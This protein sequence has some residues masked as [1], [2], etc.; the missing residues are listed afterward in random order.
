MRRSRTFLR[1]VA[2]TGAPGTPRHEVSHCDGPEGNRTPNLLRAK[3]ALFSLSYGGPTDRTRCARV[4]APRCP[5]L[6]SNQHLSLL[7]GARPSSCQGSWPEGSNPLETTDSSSVVREPLRTELGADAPGRARGAMERVGIEPTCSGE[8]RCYGP[9][10]APAASAPGR[11]NLANND[12]R[13]TKTS[14]KE[15]GSASHA[16]RRAERQVGG[17]RARGRRRRGSRSERGG[18]L[19]QR[20]SDLA[21]GTKKAAP[22]SLGGLSL[23]GCANERGSLGVIHLGIEEMV[24]IIATRTAKAGALES[25]FAAALRLRTIQASSEAGTEHRV[26]QG[27]PEHDRVAALLCRRRRRPA[28]GGREG[29][30]ELQDESHGEC[31]CCRR[32]RS[33]CQTKKNAANKIE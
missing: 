23:R 30:L 9:R 13:M 1:W 29:A 19:P 15:R 26:A 22:V 18:W 11:R 4:R 10:A 33:V 6:D 17:P 27:G 12:V 14:S 5:G 21:D 31:L 25:R 2:I 8:R 16:T 32:R 3:Q 20:E 24:A 28:W 7:H